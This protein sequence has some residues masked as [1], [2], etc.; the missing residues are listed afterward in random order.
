MQRGEFERIVH[1]ISEY[2]QIDT[3]HNH[4][5]LVVA[6]DQARS[7]VNINDASDHSLPQA[8]YVLSRFQPDLVLEFFAKFTGVVFFNGLNGSNFSFTRSQMQTDKRFNM[9]KLRRAIAALAS[10]P[11]NEEDIEDSIED[12]V[13]DDIDHVQDYMMSNAIGRRISLLIRSLPAGKQVTYRSRLSEIL[14][15]DTSSKSKEQDA[16]AILVDLRKDSVVKRSTALNVLG[17]R[18]Y[19]RP[20]P[21]LEPEVIDRRQAPTLNDGARRSTLA[22][23]DKTYVRE[24]LKE[25][26]QLVFEGLGNRQEMP[27]ILKE[28]EIENTSDLLNRKDTYRARFEDDKG[29]THTIAID[30]PRIHNGNRMTIGGSTKSILKQLTR[31]PVVKTKPN[32]VEITTQVNKVTIEVPNS[33]IFTAEVKML[34]DSIKR[35]KLDSKYYKRGNVR[36]DNAKAVIPFID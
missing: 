29:A 11:S 31:L 22:G 35:F 30:V 10:I 28:I 4:R 21:T 12:S 20:I 19:Q 8:L 27:L 13:A 2:T 6:V 1:V 36:A 34:T 3:D 26:L 7:F 14:K 33:S 24:S 25:D 9:I 15:G 18:E 16:K 23:F 17:A 32:R 5:I